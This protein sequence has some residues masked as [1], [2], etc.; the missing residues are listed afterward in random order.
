MYLSVINVKEY[1]QKPK[2]LKM[3]SVFLLFFFTA[4]LGFSQNPTDILLT[5]TIP[6]LLLANSS[7]DYFKAKKMLL[8]LEKEDGEW[9]EEKLRLLSASYTHGDLE[10]FKKELLNLVEHYGF[11][12]LQLNN[13]L[14]Y[15]EALTS[16]ELSNWFKMNYP[17][18]RAKWLENNLDKLPYIKALN[19][20]YVKDQ[21]LASLFSTINSQNF[22]NEKTK[23][24]LDSIFLEE[25]KNHFSEL[26]NIYNKIGVY[27]S[28]KSFAIPHS[29]YFLV[30]MHALKSPSI[31]FECLE[32]IYPFYEKAYLN[33]EITYLVFRDFDTQLLFSTGKQYFGTVKE[34]E[35]P[36]SFLDENGEIPVIDEA[37]LK[38]RR[39]KLQWN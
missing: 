22:E 27:P 29:P 30:E 13:S 3:K 33:K 12:I 23:K 32:Q 1:L 7:E 16:G 11:D 37:Y 19:D 2:S 36:E 5:Q 8:N 39:V 34:S 26:L 24:M 10:F 17:P 28:A 21:T 38:E 31:S 14:N 25:T 15:Y 20:L 6:K 4:F 35:V 18:L 9:P